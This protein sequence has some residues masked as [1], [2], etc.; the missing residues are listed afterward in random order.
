MPPEELLALIRQGENSGVEFKRDDLRREQQAALFASG[1]RLHAERLPVSG[2]APADLDRARLTEVRQYTG[3]PP[4]F[5][6]TDDFLRVTLP[7]TPTAK[8]SL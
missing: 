1:G 5:E 2:S 8:H 7:I 4:V 3:S 6:A